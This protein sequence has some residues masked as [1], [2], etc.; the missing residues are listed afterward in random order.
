VQHTCRTW[1]SHTSA[2]GRSAD[3]RRSRR[4]RR[5]LPRSSRS[6]GS[7]ERVTR[8]IETARRASRPTRRHRC[9]R[10]ARPLYVAARPSRLR[11][12]RRRAEI[13]GQG[14]IAQDQHG[15]AEG[16]QVVWRL[17]GQHAWCTAWLSKDHGLSQPLAPAEHAALLAA[18]SPERRSGS[19]GSASFGPSLLE[20]RRMRVSSG[21]GSARPWRVSW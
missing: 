6:R 8:C 14:W 2:L 12:H 11:Q 13:L 4:A 9:S 19:Q 1:G 7:R 5:A 16:G 17:R 20:G 18:V 15:R 10:G 21:R 3:C